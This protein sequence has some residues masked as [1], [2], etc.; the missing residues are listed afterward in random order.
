MRKTDREKIFSKYGGRCAYC[1][2]VL[3]QDWQ[4]D[5]KTPVYW[6]RMMNKEGVNAD[7]NLLPSDKKV[8]HYKR[9]SD[10]SLFRKTLSTLHLRVAKLP[11]NP[12]T[13]KGIKRKK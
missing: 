6:F 1:G 11:K 9:G 10:A 13:E 3:Q 7:E 4:V 8:N 12:Y 5:H 2:C